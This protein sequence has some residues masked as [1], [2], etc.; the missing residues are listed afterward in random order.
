MNGLAKKSSK[1]RILAFSVGFGVV[2]DDGT[3]HYYYDGTD[4]SV[5]IL[6]AISVNKR[7][8]AQDIIDAFILRT[9]TK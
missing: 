2:M 8:D 7:Q 6:D 3:E 4:W 1:I 9:H 5:S